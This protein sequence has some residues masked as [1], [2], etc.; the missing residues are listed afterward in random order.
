MRNL[1]GAGFT[2]G[3]FDAVQSFLQELG[4]I[5]T[6]EYII[7]GAFG[8]LL[9][10]T[11]AVIIAISSTYEEKFTRAIRKFNKYTT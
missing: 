1:F 4:K 11:F 10:I 3:V 2:L 6:W 7:L 8:L 5:V 9:V